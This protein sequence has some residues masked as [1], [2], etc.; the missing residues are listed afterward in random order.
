MS[1][2]IDLSLIIFILLFC[3]TSQIEIYLVLLIF[4]LIH[5]IGHLCIGMCLGFRPQEIKILPIGMRI[6]F[7]PQYE[8]Y[9]KKVKKANVLAIKRAIIAMAGP[10]VNFAIIFILVI[11]EKI[12]SQMLN[13]SIGNINYITIIYANFLIKKFKRNFSYC[14]WFEKIIYIYL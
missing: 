4:A 14:S 6:E 1:I 7:K 11:I 12:N 8:E 9:N 13:W 10:L 3:F 5:E 2:K